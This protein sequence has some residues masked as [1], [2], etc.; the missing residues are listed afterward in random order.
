MRKEISFVIALCL[1][2]LA[3]G[4]DTIA[5]PVALRIKDPIEFFSTPVIS[6]YP[7]T[8][9]AVVLRSIAIFI[10]LILILSLFEKKQF[11]KAAVL[12]FIAGVFE[13]YAIQQL[14]SG[15]RTTPIQ[16][17]LS[18]AYA[19]IISPIGLIYYI[20]SGIFGGVKEK[21]GVKEEKEYPKPIFEEEN[22]S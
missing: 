19:G 7:L 20:L 11:I 3:W 2:A 16:W 4:L 8:G 21:L 17:T 1:F 15:I 13:L 18:F 14:A 10:S 6:K 9:V 22:K 12:L 5:G